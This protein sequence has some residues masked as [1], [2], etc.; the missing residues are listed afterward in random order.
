MTDPDPA[1]P[2]PLMT[3]HADSAMKRGHFFIPDKRLILFSVL[4]RADN[5]R[6]RFMTL[7]SP[8]RPM[9]D[10][11]GCMKVPPVSGNSPPDP[12]IQYP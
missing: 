1:P 10:G 2:S 9:F 5:S 6:D 3:F 11:S 12:E 4:R 8:F 7:P